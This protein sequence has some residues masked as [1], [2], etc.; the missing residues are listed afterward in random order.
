MEGINKNDEVEMNE[1]ENID[2]ELDWHSLNI[3]SD[4]KIGQM[5]QNPLYRS[6]ESNRKRKGASNKKRRL[7]LTAVHLGTHCSIYTTIFFL[8]VSFAA[9]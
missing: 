3:E 9:T 8:L 6:V 7:S 5:Y 2:H 4:N 1:K